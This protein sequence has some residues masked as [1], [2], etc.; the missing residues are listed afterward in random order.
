MSSIQEIE[1]AILQL[2]P[3]QMREVHE[4]LE[5]L[6]EDQLEFKDEFRAGVEEAERELAQGL[7]PRVRRP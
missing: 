6:L 7:K 2:P 4:W 5:N 1:S 3:E